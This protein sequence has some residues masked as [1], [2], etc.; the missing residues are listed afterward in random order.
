MSEVR[1]KSEYELYEELDRLNNTL[2]VRIKD[3]KQDGLNYAIAEKNYKVELRKAALHLREEG[4][5]IT[6]IDKVVYGLE[7]VANLRLARDSYEA[8]YKATQESINTIKL[9]IRILDNQIQ[10]EY[11]NV[12]N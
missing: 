6:L 3:L 2:T 1:M 10:R 12:R 4:M 9:Q 5:A 11:G 7:S 8:V